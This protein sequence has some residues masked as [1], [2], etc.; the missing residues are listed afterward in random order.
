MQRRSLFI[1]VVIAMSIFI[2]ALSPNC[3]AVTQ[4]ASDFIDYNGP[5]ALAM[6]AVSI[7]LADGSIAHLSNPAA[8]V[9]IPRSQIIGGANI[10]IVS[11]ESFERNKQ[12]LD[13]SQNYFNP[14]RSQSFV[15]RN[16]DVF[17][18]AISRGMLCDYYM[19]QEKVEEK[20]RETSSYESKGGLYSISASVAKKVVPKLAIGGSLNIIRG[21]RDIE[22]LYTIEETTYD[23]DWITETEE[24]DIQTTTYKW[25]TESTESG[26]NISLGGLYNLT[27]QI[28]VAAVY[29][30]GGEITRKQT[31]AKMTNGKTD[32]T[33]STK[34][35]WTYPA[36]MGVG[37]AYQYEQILLVGEIHRTNWADYQWHDERYPFFR[38]IVPPRFPEMLN[39]C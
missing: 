5:R 32:T 16:K 8:L 24:T 21:D 15:I 4:F 14:L 2:F 17:T 27:D 10:D 30:T 34:E 7:V 37:A 20:T 22:S 36:S 33:D 19:K 29:K 38:Q 35:K 28:N 18:G 25:T 11:E 13:N 3:L 23:W 9:M 1:I 6:G 26:M 31:S 39:Y 12:V